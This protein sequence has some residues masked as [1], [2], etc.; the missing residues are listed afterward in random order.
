MVQT[1]GLRAMVDRDPDHD[2]RSVV[3]STR[4]HPPC[5]ETCNHAFSWVSSESPAQHGPIQSHV[6]PSCL[7]LVFLGRNE[8]LVRSYCVAAP[9]GWPMAVVI[10][11][12]CIYLDPPTVPNFSLLA[13]FT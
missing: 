1:S 11:G 2:P 6:R 13:G 4:F 5:N 3:A 9:Y 8:T 12:D 7:V 10:L